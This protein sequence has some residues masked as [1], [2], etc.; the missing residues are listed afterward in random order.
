MLDEKKLL[1]SLEG[2][3]GPELERLKDFLAG[4]KLKSLEFEGREIDY[5]ICGEGPQTLLSFAG[6]WGPPQLLYETILSFEETSRVVVVDISPFREP[7]I[8]CR[9]INAV[10]KTEGLDQVILLGQS[11]TGIIAQLYFRRNFRRVNGMVLTC[12]PAPLKEKCKKWALNL[13]RILPVGLFKPIVKKKM[14]GYLEFEKEVSDKVKNRLMFRTELMKNILGQYF[15]RRVMLSAVELAFAFSWEGAYQPDE[16]HDW[17]G[18]ILIITCEDDPLHAD[19]EVL[20]SSLPSAEMFKL[21]TGFKHVAP[22]VK[23]EDVDARIQNFIGGL[24]H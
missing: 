3:E 14:S 23:K 5:L 9:G 11:F 1:E 4:H 24:R 12:T 19:A 16:F 10:L 8:M 20:I 22:L 13:M 7:D 2:L 6:G 17:Q 15:N 21:P 18:K